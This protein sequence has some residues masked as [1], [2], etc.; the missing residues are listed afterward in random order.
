[1]EPHP[2]TYQKELVENPPAF[3]AEIKIRLFITP[4]LRLLGKDRSLGVNY[5]LL[6]ALHDFEKMAL[7]ISS[8]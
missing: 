4:I 6:K 2:L 7:L 1:M 5:Q 8:S 3:E